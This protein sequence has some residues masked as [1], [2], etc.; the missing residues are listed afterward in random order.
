MCDNCNS[1]CLVDRFNTPKDY[2]KCLEYIKGLVSHGNFIIESQTCPLD[3]VINEN[4]CWSDD[5][6]R[7]IIVCKKCRSA[8]IC[9]CDTYHG[10]GSFRVG[11]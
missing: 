6:I 4:G 7:H 11:R 8:Y 1:I 5:F 2:L 9:S 10:N 3:E